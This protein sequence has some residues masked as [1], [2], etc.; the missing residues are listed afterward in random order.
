MK[1]TIKSSLTDNI[2]KKS[3]KLHAEKSFKLKL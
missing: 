3:D 2:L 1:L